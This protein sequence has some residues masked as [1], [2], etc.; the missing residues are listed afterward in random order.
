MAMMRRLGSLA[1]LLL[2]HHLQ[3]RDDEYR[4]GLTAQRQM[5]LADLNN[6][7]R[8]AAAEDAQ[9]QS[10]LL[11]GLENPTLMAQY[12]RSGIDLGGIDP[13][14]FKP[15]DE[16]I[17]AQLGTKIA[18]SK[19]EELPTDLGVENLLG[20]DPW[21]QSLAKDPRAVKQGMVAR[22]DRR[23]QLN[24][25]A[26]F[27]TDQSNARAFGQRY[28]EA[29]GTESAASANA[30][31]Q[32]AR[33]VTKFNTM[34]PLEVS[35][36]A[37]IAGADTRARLAA[38]LDPKVIAAKL[39]FEKQKNLLELANAQNRAGAEIYAAKEA[40]VKGLLPVYQ[41]YRVLA[42]ELMTDPKINTNQESMSTIQ[43]ALSKLPWFGEFAGSA[44]EAYQVSKSEALGQVPGGMMGV[45][46]ATAQKMSQLN[47]LTDTL[48]QG[49]ANAIIGNRGATSEN[50]RRTAKAVLVN[51]LTSA[52]SATEL[53]SL[54]DKMFTILPRVA[55]ANPA[56]TPAD[57]INL[58]AEEAR[59]NSS[60]A[61]ATQTPAT[62]AP[63]TPNPA[64]DAARAK[65]N[66][67]RGVQ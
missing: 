4:S 19:R 46:A 17:L 32:L 15:S 34:T 8:A 62:P 29:M 56:A 28:N 21:G 3:Q 10:M 67:A 59:G 9:K 41:Q 42:V 25:I 20:A 64:L 5:E 54:T 47:R 63:A 23:N 51:T 40:A 12:A 43:N 44:M 14:A 49:M 61:A 11:K 31:A 27:E 13:N 18:Q 36:S 57:V 2:R 52:K 38:E 55:A 6:K 22:D 65:L 26:A 7:A 30:P 16:M 35:R 24:E 66:R 39:D 58:A 60:V 48:A 37:Q 50:D 45:D 1:D 33:D 53:I